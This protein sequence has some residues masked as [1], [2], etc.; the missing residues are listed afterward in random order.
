MR[1]QSQTNQRKPKE[2]RPERA[3]AAEIC[4]CAKEVEVA[5]EEEETSG[6]ESPRG[7]FKRHFQS[8]CGQCCV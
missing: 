7:I 4:R 6:G 5:V 8:V 1:S 3:E 2:T